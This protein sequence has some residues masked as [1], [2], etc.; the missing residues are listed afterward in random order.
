[1]MAAMNRIRRDMVWGGWGVGAE[2][3]RQAGGVEES[4]ERVAR[5]KK[6]GKIITR[7]RPPPFPFQ[8][9]TNNTTA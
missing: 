2:R 6:R 1:M 5:K 4:G 9:C 7:P 3:K 8:F